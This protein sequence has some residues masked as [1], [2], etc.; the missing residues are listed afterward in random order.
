MQRRG[1]F[2]AVSVC[3]LVVGLLGGTGRPSPPGPD[4]LTPR[5]QFVM[6]PDGSSGLTEG[7]ARHPEHRL[8]Q[9]DDPH[10]LRRL[11][12]RHRRQ[13]EL[14]VHHRDRQEPR[15]RGWRTLAQAPA[16]QPR[17][18][19][20]RRRHDAL[21]LRHGGRGDALQ[22][23]PGPPG[24]RG[25]RTRSS[26]PRRAWPTSSTRPPGWAITVFG[27]TG[28]SDDQ[29]AATL[30]QPDQGRLHRVQ[31]RQVL[32]EVDGTPAPSQQ[33]TRYITCADD[34]A[35]CTT[36]EYKAGT[37][38]HIEADAAALQHRPQHRR[39]VVR[40]AG[41]LRRH[42]RSSCRTRRTTCRA[43]NIPARR[44]SRDLAP[45]TEFTMAADGSSGATEGG[46][47]IPNIDSVKSTIR[48][49]YGAT[50]GIAEQDRSPYITEMT[51]LARQ[52]GPAADDTLRQPGRQGHRARPSS[53]TPTTP[54]CGPT[55]WRT[56]RCTS[57]STRSSRTT[58]VQEREFPAVA[59]HGRGR[60]RRGRRWL[61]GRRPDRPQRRP[62]RGD[63]GQPAQVSTTQTRSGRSTTSPSGPSA[64]QPPAYVDLRGGATQCTTH[65]VQV[66]DPRARPRTT[67]VH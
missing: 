7:G 58:W 1:T 53:S 34:A 17:R 16:S 56:R 49:Y 40:P 10:L 12:R 46:E 29:E 36:V 21:D 24:R 6:K 2:A 57:T 60:P 35:K 63:A 37:R 45:H 11:Q 41:R 9:G 38:K 31:R 30:G 52:V 20:R 42:R 48:A 14:A 28:R 32:H 8:G 50:D 5:T 13:D 23:R 54:R 33:P 55:T 66:A 61:Q 18:R 64:R 27:I 4:P 26:R 59:G 51:A 47:G 19:L 39:P 22:L 67:W 43:P 15:G 25:C 44:P 3:A 65:G 62:A